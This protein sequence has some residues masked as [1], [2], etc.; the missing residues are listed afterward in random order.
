MIMKRL[1]SV[2]AML[3]I[4]CVGGAIVAQAFARQ[5]P[6]QN[7]PAIGTAVP[8]IETGFIIAA[9]VDVEGVDVPYAPS[10]I[11]MLYVSRKTFNRLRNEAG[12]SSA[13]DREGLQLQVITGSG[14]EAWGIPAGSHVTLSLSR[15]GVPVPE[16][17]VAGD[18]WFVT[19]EA[20]LSAPCP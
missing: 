17:I 5:T 10:G 3:A 6:A 9:L 7:A 18:D 8:S 13:C 20:V 11:S 14:A 1:L 16:T 4:G 12:G 15:S 2:F 19:G